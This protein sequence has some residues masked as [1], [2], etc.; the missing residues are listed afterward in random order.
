MANGIDGIYAAIAGNLGSLW[1][2]RRGGRGRI[3]R[4]GL[5][6]RLVSPA[7]QTNGTYVQP[8]NA[9]VKAN[10]GNFTSR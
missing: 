8:S 3:L 2:N 5:T 7:K 9:A 1:L 4:A 10:A 6:V